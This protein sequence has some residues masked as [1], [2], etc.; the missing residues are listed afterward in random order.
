M[1]NLK[2]VRG[3]TL[4]RRESDWKHWDKEQQALYK[5][6]APCFPCFVQ[7]RITA[8]EEETYDYL[9]GGMIVDM[10]AILQGA[11]GLL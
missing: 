3:W 5:T 10:L 9:T 11:E 1:P 8:D 6:P 4:L 7:G 2:I